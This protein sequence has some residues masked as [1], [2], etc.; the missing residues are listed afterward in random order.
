M[1]HYKRGRVSAEGRESAL[2]SKMDELRSRGDREGA[3]VE[4]KE[5]AATVAVGVMARLTRSTRATGVNTD[6][7]VGQSR[8]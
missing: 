4:G 8:C 7:E 1:L 3:A 5:K 6:E 2:K